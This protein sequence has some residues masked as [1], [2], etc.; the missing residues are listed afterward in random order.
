MNISYLKA[1]KFLNLIEKK[2]VVN[3]TCLLIIIIIATA[4][5]IFIP[6]GE[7]T[8]IEEKNLNSSML[9]IFFIKIMLFDFSIMIII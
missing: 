6:N 8:E 4:L 1:L 5:I 9:A 2:K 3:I 7:T